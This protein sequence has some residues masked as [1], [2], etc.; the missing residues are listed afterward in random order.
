MLYLEPR[1][2]FPL[3]GGRATLA[4]G[5]DAGAG[6]FPTALGATTYATGQAQAIANCQGQGLANGFSAPGDRRA[7]WWPDLRKDQ[8]VA[9]MAVKVRF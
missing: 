5:G 1:H 2:G 7:L 8:T 6:Y 4:A 9:T 3:T